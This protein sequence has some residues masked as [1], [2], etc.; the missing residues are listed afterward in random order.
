[1]KN[2]LITTALLLATFAPQVEAQQQNL[3]P[4][5]FVSASIEFM[6]ESDWSKD[7]IG[8]QSALKYA[9]YAFYGTIGG[10]TSHTD[11]YSQTYNYDK[12]AA[13]YGLANDTNIQ[14][15]ADTI[16]FKYDQNYSEFSLVNQTIFTASDGKQVLQLDFT[17]RTTD[18]R[19]KL[20]YERQLHTFVD[21]LYVVFVV[22][23]ERD[24]KEFPQFNTDHLVNT[25]TAKNREPSPQ[26]QE[27]I[28]DLESSITEALTFPDVPETHS[29]WQGIAHT[30]FE[31][32]FTGYPD[33]TFKPDNA[34][35][36]AELVKVLFTAAGNLKA[37]AITSSDFKDVP[38]DAWFAPYVQKAKLKGIVKGYPDGT[39]KPEQ[40][41][42]LAE[43]LKMIYETL[44]I[45]TTEVDGAW[46]E[47]YLA[48]AKANGVLFSNNVQPNTDV[49]RKTVAW[50]IWKL[51]GGQE[52][53]VNEP[54]TTASEDTV[55]SRLIGV[56]HFALE[57]ANDQSEALSTDLQNILNTM[58]AY[59]IGSAR[60]EDS[61]AMQNMLAVHNSLNAQI[62]NFDALIATLNSLY[63]GGAVQYST[64]S[65]P[66][67]VAADGVLTVAA[68]K[69]MKS[70]ANDIYIE[71][72][73]LKDYMRVR[74][75][76]ALLEN[77]RTGLE[78]R[79]ANTVPN[80]SD[81]TT[82]SANLN[83]VSTLLVELEVFADTSNEPLF[84]DQEKE[85][86]M[87]IEQIEES[88]ANIR[89]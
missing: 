64:I 78:E 44:E 71:N 5:Q 48:H 57:N 56:I 85:L 46:Y 25:V 19:N 11:S 15:V 17:Y 59:V 34:I 81:Y 24:L 55:D 23:S 65:G 20:I 33:G 49:D 18:G 7:H 41:V 28:D 53:P 45:E 52:I 67:S 61:E 22:N 36:R 13:V 4:V 73:R 29:H 50:I 32:I 42:I 9:P 12:V 79:M 37:T 74:M 86:S 87:L 88:I 27:M 60:T 6:H 89:W 21:D 80:T 51:Q 63:E 83:T 75:W 66:N 82:Y 84:S 2:V 16:A 26:V 40:T 68:Y 69:K 31:K 8:A 3:A 1:M 58:K 62:S 14:D 76:Q 30:K 47:R 72:Q 77:M 35:N 39:F 43:A 70:L 54:E 38:L 10:I